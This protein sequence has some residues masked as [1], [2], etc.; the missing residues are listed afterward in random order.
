MNENTPLSRLK[1][2]LAAFIII[3]LLPLIAHFRYSWMGFNPTDDGFILSY[4][5]RLIEGQIPHLDFISIR[6]IGS[7]LLHLPFVLFG[8]DYTYWI[9]RFFVWFEFAVIAWLWTLIV[10]RFRRRPFNPFE[11]TLTAIIIFGISF[12]YFPVMAWH[13]IDG[14]ALSSLGLYLIMKDKSAVFNNIGY[15]AL[16]MAY[17]CKQNF[18]I[19]GIIAIFLFGD[20]KNYKNWLSLLIPGIIYSFILLSLGALPDMATQLIAQSNILLIGII[21]YVKLPLFWAGVALGWLGGYLLSGPSKKIA[22]RRYLSGVLIFYMAIIGAV[23]GIAIGRFIESPAFGFF[24]LGLGLLIQIIRLRRNF[25]SR[26]WK[27]AL[28]A[29]LFAW[30]VSLSVGYNSPAL[31]AGMIAALFLAYFFNHSPSAYFSRVLVVA[32]ILTTLATAFAFDWTRRHH[33]Y[34]DRPADELT[35]SLDGVLP[36]GKNIK[37]NPRTH[38]FLVDLRRAIAQSGGGRYAIIPDCA[39]YWAKAEQ[40]NPLPIDWPQQV[41]LS[42]QSLTKRVT[43]AIDSGRDST[44]IIVQKNLADQLYKEFFPLFEGKKYEVVYYVRHNLNKVGETNLFEIYR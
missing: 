1:S 33:I 38:E 28:T 19:I 27:T 21:A 6:P 26:E 32:M 39:G 35:F 7:A 15:L 2:L 29:I 44:Y 4:S 10:E 12:N 31:G 30:T 40:V 24:G 14:M 34:R 13:T 17:L 16:G 23:I 22:A 37:T 18:I 9:S 41:E 43:D 11:K 20:R 42:A 5:R 8:G 36:G 3:P 25:S